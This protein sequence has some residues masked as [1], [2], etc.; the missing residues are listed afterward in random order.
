MPPTSQRV[1][2]LPTGC[3]IPTLQ[4]LATRRGRCG[5]WNNC[6]GLICATLGY[7][8]RYILDL[9]DHVWLEIG[10][11]SEARWMHVDACEATCDTPL[12]YYAG[13][14]KPSMSYCWAIDRHAVVDVSARYID[15]QDRDV[16]QRRAAALP[17]NER[18]PFLYAVNA[19][20]Q[21]TMGATQRRA[22][23]HRLVEEQRA[24]A[25]A[26]SHPLDQRPPLPGR[27]TGSRSWRLE[28]G[29]LG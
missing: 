28:R 2:H 23:L 14:K 27:Q 4:L 29:E 12:L 24:L 6:F 15:L 26:A 1:H 17:V 18:I 5:E 11:P 25:I 19:P 10:R 7:P 8:V 20:L 21:R 16:V 3:A 13:W 22:M 9:S